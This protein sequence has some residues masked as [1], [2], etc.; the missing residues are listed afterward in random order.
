MYNLY[1]MLYMTA[2]HKQIHL[3]GTVTVGPK[4]QV[5]IPAEVREGMAIQ[6]GDKLVALYFDDKKSVAF[7]T[8]QQAQEYVQKMGQH[9]TQFKTQLENQSET[10]NEEWD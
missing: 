1:N 7:I 3:A 5:V 6:P 10:T 8:E 2:F 9:F 4:G